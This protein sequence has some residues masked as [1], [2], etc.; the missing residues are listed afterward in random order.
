MNETTLLSLSASLVATLFGLLVAIIGWLGSKIY[1]KL[2]E[3]GNTMRRI[4]NDLHER[5]SALDKRVTRVETQFE[6]RR[7][8]DRIV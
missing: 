1:S 8:T 5:I 4:E 3:L 7:S 2:D 6:L